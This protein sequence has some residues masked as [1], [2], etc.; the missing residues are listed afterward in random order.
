MAALT[1][2]ASPVILTSWILLECVHF[3][4]SLL[5]Q[6]SPSLANCSDLPA[7]LL[8]FSLRLFPTLYLG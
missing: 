4:L 5:S 8:F 6:P 3:S 7:G 1:P 2:S